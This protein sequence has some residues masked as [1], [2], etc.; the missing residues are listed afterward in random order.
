MTGSA[1]FPLANNIPGDN[2]RGMERHF[3][4]DT[5]N[6]LPTRY[7]LGLQGLKKPH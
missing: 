3:K 4:N 6:H 2:T 5:R 7:G 1:E